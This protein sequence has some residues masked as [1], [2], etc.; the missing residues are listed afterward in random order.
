MWP[1]PWEEAG[2]RSARPD[3]MSCMADTREEALAWAEQLV[4]EHDWSFVGAPALGEHLWSLVR[5]AGQ[6]A[7]RNPLQRLAAAET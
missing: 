4:Q 7:G 5:A 2:L 6:G 3:R 1:V